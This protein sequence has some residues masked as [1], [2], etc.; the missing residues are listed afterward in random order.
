VK[1]M[2]FKYGSV[3]AGSLEQSST[4]DSRRPPLNRHWGSDE[5]LVRDLGLGVKR[6]LRDDP[7]SPV[8]GTAYTPARVAEMRKDMIMWNPPLQNRVN[9]ARDDNSLVTGDPLM[10]SAS[11]ST[12]YPRRVSFFDVGGLL[13]E[14][15]SQGRKSSFVSNVDPMLPT[16]DVPAPSVPAGARGVQRGSAALLRD[17]AGLR[18]AHTPS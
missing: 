15:T 12:S 2:K 4:S 18:G 8:E 10:R 9:G 13:D 11:N 3:A 14:R 5:D 17:I 6:E 7:D 1:K 16:H